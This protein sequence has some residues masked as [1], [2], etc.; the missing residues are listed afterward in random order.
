MSTF[1][2][3]R[4]QETQE[5]QE[6][7]SGEPLTTD[8]SADPIP[9]RPT[10]KGKFLFV[11]EDKLRVK[12]VTYGAFRPDRFGNE[13]HDLTKIENDFAAMAAAGFNVVRIPHTTP[14]RALLDI[15]QEHGLR[16]MIG[17]SA[18][19]Y[20]GHL[21]D[22]PFGSLGR[23]KREIR[24]KVRSCASHPAVL[25]YALGNEV[26][27]QMVR[28]IGPRKIERYLR[29]L[30]DAVREED[31]G[32]LVTYVN[33]PTT[34]YLDLHFLDLIAMNVYLEDP[35]TLSSYL[36]RLQNIAGERPLLLSEVGLDSMRHGLEGQAAT[37]DWQIRTAAESG[38]VGVVLFSWTDEWYRG[39]EDV[40]DWAFGL[41]DHARNPKPALAAVQRAFSGVESPVPSDPPSMS[42][43]LCSYNGSRT[44]S[45]SL[46]ALLELD[47]PDYEVIVV[48]DGS[49]DHTAALADRP[50]VRLIRAAHGGL[51]NARNT[52]LHAAKGDIVAYIDDDAYPDPD[53]LAHLAAT[54]TSSTHAGVGGPNISPPS[55][56][57]ISQCVSNSPGNPSH[58]LLDDHEAEHIPGCN[59]AF[60]RDALLAIGGFDSQFRSA[61]DDVDVCWRLRDAGFTLGFS[62][63]AVVWHHRRGSI[64]AYLKQQVGYGRA[65]HMLSRKWRERLSGKTRLDWLGTIYGS[66]HTRPLTVRRPRVYHG[67]WGLAPFQSV[68]E[69]HPGRVSSMLLAPRFW[70][71]V[72][73]LSA[74]VAFG[75]GATPLLW[76]ALPLVLAILA[77]GTQ[78]LATA[79]RA[80]FPAATLA[81]HRRGRLVLVTALLHVLQPLARL[82]GQ[83]R[84][85]TAHGHFR[86][87][88]FFGLAWPVPTNR[89]LWTGNWQPDHERLAALESA[90]EAHEAE[91]IPGHHEGRWDLEVR[92]GSL[93]AAR[94][95]LAGEDHKN[96][97][98]LVRIRV[99]PYVEARGLVIL[100]TLAAGFLLS[101][102]DSASLVAAVFATG[103]AATS[104]VVIVQCS[105]A[106]RS[107]LAILS[108]SGF[109]RH[110]ESK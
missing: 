67:V 19:Q 60:R 27:A 2:R 16:V 100:A 75:L 42:V 63:A 52:G 91:V 29:V 45:E 57:P 109:A 103:F 82:W 108:R 36:A 33:Y 83:L 22:R 74:L 86:P 37:L 87:R 93:G 89:V 50:G 46:D 14:P 13:F 88:R 7:P 48:D 64:R 40:E 58:V 79:R 101:W 11:G 56:G 6:S 70:L 12:G 53:W 66:G 90:L 96:R 5:T 25:C 31:P 68:Y 107:F 51:S 110:V 32:A 21:L 38:C 61:G 102:S 15:A 69:P 65:E 76:A 105:S 39:G 41:T 30:C 95:R 77:L 73:A 97:H 71:V 80:T 26:P 3:V 9:L 104:L 23:I 78:A 98:Q 34:E 8:A 10:V 18:E 43:V 81:T 62:P 4:T 49:T 55:D 92:G 35:A 72:L 99:W 17:L 24:K 59:M 54:F 20:V 106:M 44:I 84:P 85:P 94:C 28:F 1:D 47:Y